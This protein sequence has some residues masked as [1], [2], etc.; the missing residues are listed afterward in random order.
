M[1][2]RFSVILP[3][4][5]EEHYISRVLDF[6]IAAKPEN[7]ELIIADG[8]STD[9]TREIVSEYSA[10]TPG[11]ILIS[12]PDRFVPFA[13]NACI[14]KSTGEFIV[15]LDAHTEYAP[16]YFTKVIETFEKTGAE[17]VGGPMRAK[18]KTSFQRAVAVCTSTMFGVGDSKFHDDTAEG[19]TDSVYLG[20]WRRNIFETTGYFDEAMLRNQDDEFHYRAKSKGMKIYLN[21]EIKSWY[22]PRSNI[23]TLTKQYF[24]YGLF[25]PLVLKK[26]RSEIKPRHLIPSAFLLYLISIPILFL[27]TGWMAVVPLIIYLAFDLLFSFS[28]QDKIAEKFNALVIYPALHISYGSGFLLGLSNS[29]RKIFFKG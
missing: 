12:N 21:P 1:T 3:C 4:R 13:L 27:M 28:R 2:G 24:Q 23:R 8:A 29:L 6:F 11:I 17:I 22:Y 14:R 20:A 18:G 25:K 5:N 15:R 19:F 7:K 16:D 26:V 10:K 9:R